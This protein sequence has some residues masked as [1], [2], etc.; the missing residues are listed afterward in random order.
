MVFPVSHRSLNCSTSEA[1]QRRL[2][3]LLIHFVVENN[4]WRF[5]IG[6][7]E[8]VHSL[9]KVLGNDDKS[10]DVSKV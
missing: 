1:Q 6:L 7:V 4:L 2:N 5:Q 3:F 10:D 9:V 8:L